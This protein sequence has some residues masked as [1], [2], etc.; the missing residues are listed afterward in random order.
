MKVREL[1]EDDVF[2]ELSYEDE[3]LS[4]TLESES[5]GATAFMLSEEATDTLKAILFS[6][7]TTLQKAKQAQAKKSLNRSLWDEARKLAGVHPFRTKEIY[8]R[9]KAEHEELTKS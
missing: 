1:V 5:R 3:R 7:D 4:I 2:V 6:L 9:L 8:Q